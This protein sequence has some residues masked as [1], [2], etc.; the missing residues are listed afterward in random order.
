[1]EGTFPEV[2]REGCSPVAGAVAVGVLQS[3][4][5]EIA[6]RL[7]QDMPKGALQ[8]DVMDCG[9]VGMWQLSTAL[10]VIT[11]NALIGTHEKGKQK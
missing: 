8:T 11:C 6:F 3:V 10:D 5:G 1:M 9:A 2:S 7:L 4:Q